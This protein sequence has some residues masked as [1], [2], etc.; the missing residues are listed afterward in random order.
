MKREPTTPAGALLREMSL[1]QLK[2]FLDA[3]RDLVFSPI[4][5][6]AALFDVILLKQQPPRFF[7]DVLRMGKRSDEW[8]DLW[9][10]IEQREQVPENVDA[11]VDRVEEI[12]RDP[13]TSARRA[14]VLKRRLKRHLGR[15]LAAP[16]KEPVSVMNFSATFRGRRC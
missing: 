3:A 1:L 7:H 10:P 4:V 11:L 5:L 14:R 8:I 9:A 2:L 16:P 12:L 15:A 13:R 6:V